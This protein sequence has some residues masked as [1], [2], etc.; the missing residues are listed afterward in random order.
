MSPSIVVV[1]NIHHQ[2][3]QQRNMSLR[4]LLLLS[5]KLMIVE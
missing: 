3:R 5:S 1:D 4:P 2:R